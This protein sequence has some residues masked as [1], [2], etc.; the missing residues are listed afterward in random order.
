MNE[1]GIYNFYDHYV[2]S[3]VTL[4]YKPQFQIYLMGR[5]SYLRLKIFYYLF[6][7]LFGIGL[8]KIMLNSLHRFAFQFY[9]HLR[10][11]H[12]ILV[13][14]IV[15]MKCYHFN[16]RIQV[17]QLQAYSIVPH[18]SLVILFHLLYW[19]YIIYQCIFQSV[20]VSKL[21]TTFLSLLLRQ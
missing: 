5:K 3:E 18:I 15:F 21:L 9:Y 1:S 7:Y 10:D 14:S 13:N 4:R 16:G 6:T 2:V 20:L 12:N 11:G 19:I 8:F 17:I